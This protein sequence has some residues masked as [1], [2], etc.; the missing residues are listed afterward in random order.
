MV[1]LLSLPGVVLDYCRSGEEVC[2]QTKKIKIVSLGVIFYS[3]FS[4]CQVR[5]AGIPVVDAANL[6]QNLMN[7]TQYLTDY[8]NQLQQLQ[9]QLTIYKQQV[10]EATRPISSVYKDVSSVYKSLKSTYDSIQNLRANY[11][12]TLSYIQENYGDSDFW[13]ACAS[14]GCN[15]FTRLEN[16]YDATTN[17]LSYV[18]ATNKA[19]DQS[20]QD[21][22]SALDELETEITSAK[23]ESTAA[24]LQTIGQ[25][26]AQ[27]AKA[28]LLNQ[29]T[30]EQFA[31]A[32]AAT[33]LEEKN[34]QKAAADAQNTFFKSP[35]MNYKE[36]ESYS[37]SLT[38]H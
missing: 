29:K 13:I 26:Q 11:T 18:L 10:A 24:T 5:A 22:S 1:V 14:S 35:T 33:Q 20:A 6:S 3:V 30:Q 32:F 31:S 34:R 21:I 15:P 2:M 37:F 28:I 36:R 19:V 12:S 23:T 27:T 16:A 4:V 17:E 7:Y 9:Q 38:Q 8:A 25:L